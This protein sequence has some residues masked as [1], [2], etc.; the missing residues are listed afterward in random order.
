MLDPLGNRE[1]TKDFTPLE[2]T[3]SK[4]LEGDNEI[5]FESC[6]GQYLVIPT[7]EDMAIVFEVFQKCTYLFPN[8]HDKKEK[9]STAISHQNYQLPHKEQ[10]IVN[11]ER[12]SCLFVDH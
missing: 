11:Q 9:Q 2:I 7:L 3:K 10:P 1:T 6:E 8:M 4:A 5:L 12:Y